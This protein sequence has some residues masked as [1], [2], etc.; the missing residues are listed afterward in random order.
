MVILKYFYKSCKQNQFI[1]YQKN[2]NLNI[3]KKILS[4]SGGGTS[5][6]T[7]TGH[8]LFLLDDILQLKAMINNFIQENFSGWSLWYLQERKFGL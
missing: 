2:I 6:C 8:Q 3:K 7:W 1:F 4:I 5:E